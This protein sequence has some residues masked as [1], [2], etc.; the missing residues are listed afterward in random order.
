MQFQYSSKS[1][2]K[3]NIDDLFIDQVCT[4]TELVS[5]EKD[6]EYQALGV[7]DKLFGEYFFASFNCKYKFFKNIL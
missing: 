3:T 6:L 4:I 7:G 2:L 5:E 1:P